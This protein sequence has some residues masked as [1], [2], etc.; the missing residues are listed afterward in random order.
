M[1]CNIYAFPCQCL[2]SPS[3]HLVQSFRIEAVVWSGSPCLYSVCPASRMLLSAHPMPS[4]V[5]RMWTRPLCSLLQWYRHPSFHRVIFVR[6]RFRRL[7]L[8]RR[9]C[10]CISAQV[11]AE[12]DVL[13]YYNSRVIH[14]VLEDSA[15]WLRR[16]RLRGTRSRAVY[17]AAL[18]QFS[19]LRPFDIP[20]SSWHSTRE[21]CHSIARSHQ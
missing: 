16:L 9:C 20:F 10:L 15:F 11:V 2:V 18:F 13:L 12:Q 17:G 6:C 4:Q 3:R 7:C 14:E 19:P 5:P 8:R 1:I 21:V